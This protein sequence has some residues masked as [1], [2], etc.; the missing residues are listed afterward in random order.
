MVPFNSMTDLQKMI[1]LKA[2]LRECIYLGYIN[3]PECS[4][5]W[6]EKAKEAIK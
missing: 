1:W 3:L 4:T 5:E 6:L 2:L